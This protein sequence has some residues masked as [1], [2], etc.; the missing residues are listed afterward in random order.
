MMVILIASINSTALFMLLGASTTATKV[1]TVP[2]TRSGS[3]PISTLCRFHRSLVA[4]SLADREM[5]SKVVHSTHR[6][7]RSIGSLM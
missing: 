4:P 2:V 3:E 5:H 7:R 6:D 1:V